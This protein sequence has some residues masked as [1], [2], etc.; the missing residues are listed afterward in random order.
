MIAGLFDAYSLLKIGTYK[1][2]SVIMSDLLEFN[3]VTNHGIQNLIPFTGKGA[4]GNFK[5]SFISRQ[6]KTRVH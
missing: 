2:S 3:T 5:R 1:P 6:K 4:F